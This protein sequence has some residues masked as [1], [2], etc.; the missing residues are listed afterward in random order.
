[1]DTVTLFG[2]AVPGWLP[3]A[4]LALVII[5]VLALI[6]KGFFTEMRK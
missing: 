4:L 1:M 2:L 5:I 6:L 3:W